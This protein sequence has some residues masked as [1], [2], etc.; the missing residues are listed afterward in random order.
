MSL[1]KYAF[2]LEFAIHVLGGRRKGSA[3]TNLQYRL[4]P[5]IK[6][7]SQNEA[8]LLV[9]RDKAQQIFVKWNRSNYAPNGLGVYLP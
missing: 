1:I 7:A 4:Y 6:V 2:E 9:F 8:V 5:N 3:S